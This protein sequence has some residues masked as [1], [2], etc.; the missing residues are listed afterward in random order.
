MKHSFTYQF[1]K[2]RGIDPQLFSLSNVLTDLKVRSEESKKSNYSI[3]A[4]LETIA[5]V[6]SVE[7]SN[8]IEGIFATKER[9]KAIV[10]STSIP[11]GHNEEEIAGYHDAAKFVKEHFDDL[12][13]NEATVRE[14]H[15]LLT[16][17]H[18]GFKGGEYKKGDNI[19][20]EKDKTGEVKRIIFKPVPAKETEEAMQKLFLA[21]Q[22]ARDDYEIYPLLLIP[23]V[24]VDFLSIHPFSDGNGRVSRLLTLLLLYKAGYDAGRF[25]SFEAKINEYKW[26]YYDS[27]LRSQA[28]WHENQNDYTPFIKF[29]FQVLYQC[30]KEINRRLIGVS[31]GKSKKK[32]R[33]EAVVMSSIVP[34]SKMDIVD[35]LP[36]VS[37]VTIESALT[38][39]QKEGKIKKIGTFRNARYIKK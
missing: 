20:A 21:Y 26:N 38:K 10:D 22:L 6:E 12:D 18:I 14:L 16:A 30:Y 13:F 29:T 34:M 36:D 1:L 35:F 33:V 4:K 19:I 32:D 39:L 25:V 28:H 9:I 24:I 3:F 8:A 15:R 2:E 37:I 7:G 23:C 17:R 11:L 5:I 27:L 31:E